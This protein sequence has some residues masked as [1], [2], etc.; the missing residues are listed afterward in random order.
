MTITRN[1]KAAV[2]VVCAACEF[3]VKILQRRVDRKKRVTYFTC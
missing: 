2:A 3:V 1:R